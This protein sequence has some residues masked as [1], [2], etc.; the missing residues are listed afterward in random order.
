MVDTAKLLA[1]LCDYQEL[2]WVLLT[3]L[4]FMLLLTTVS[5]VLGE[6][7]TESYIIA[8]V[9]LVLILGFG[10]VVVSLYTTCARKDE[11]I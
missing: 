2:L 4:V 8:I 5:L 1:R 9:D 10:G 11:S 3:F 6:P 7:G